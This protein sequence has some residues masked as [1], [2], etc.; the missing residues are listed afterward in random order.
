MNLYKEEEEEKPRSNE[1]FC[2]NILTLEKYHLCMMKHCV[3][4]KSMYTSKERNIIRC[5]SECCLKV[6]KIDRKKR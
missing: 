2:L 5:E 3:E 1:I 6:D 4:A